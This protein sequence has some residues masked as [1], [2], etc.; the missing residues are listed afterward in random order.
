[1]VFD[2]TTNKFKEVTGAGGGSGAGGGGGAGASAAPR[3]PAAP[4]GLPKLYTEG[5]IHRNSKTGEYLVVMP[6][7]KFGWAKTPN[8]AG[9]RHA[10][11]TGGA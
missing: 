6:D 3:A 7:G 2:P 4:G 5:G 8:G 10:E 9:A 1:M 11:A